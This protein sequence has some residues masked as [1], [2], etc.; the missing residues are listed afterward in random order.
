MDTSRSLTSKSVGWLDGKIMF[1]EIKIIGKNSVANNFL[2]VYY[3]KML[4]STLSPNTG[5]WSQDLD[6]GINSKYIDYLKYIS[7]FQKSLWIFF[8]LKCEYIPSMWIFPLITNVSTGQKKF[9][10]SLQ[11]FTFPSANKFSKFWSREAE[12]INQLFL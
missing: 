1:E 10:P 9:L 2:C 5:Q 4:R 12:W 8:P 7:L 3:T 6:L 11:Y